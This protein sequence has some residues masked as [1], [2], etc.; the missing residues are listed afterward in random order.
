[1]AGGAADTEVGTVACTVAEAEAEAD[2]G[3][4]AWPLH[5]RGWRRPRRR[6]RNP[7]RFG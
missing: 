2:Y 5:G 3:A 4:A 1:M 6:W 7:G